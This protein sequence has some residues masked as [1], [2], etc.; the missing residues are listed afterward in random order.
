MYIYLAETN[1]LHLLQ[2][3][4]YEP[5]TTNLMVN[6]DITIE[7]E[8]VETAEK[9]YK[10]TISAIKNKDCNVVSVL[11]DKTCRRGYHT[12]PRVIPP[13]VVGS[14]PIKRN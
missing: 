12:K 14:I 11:T 7:C 2:D 1:G 13:I 6:K 10:D 9:L 4:V 8:T 5:D 3:L